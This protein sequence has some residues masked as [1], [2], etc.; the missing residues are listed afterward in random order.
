MGKISD[1]FK[2]I[3]WWHLFSLVIILWIAAI[4]LIPM[5]YPKLEESGQ[6]GDMFGAV[7]AL[8]AGL[9]FAGVIWAIILQKE[10]LELQRQELKETR[11]EIRGQKEQLR[12]QDQTLQ[13][14]NF[15]SSFFQLLDLHS[16]IV[17]S[18]V[19]G[20]K[21]EYS[22]RMCFDFMLKRLKEE[23]D[24]PARA[25]TDFYDLRSPNQ[26]EKTI[27]QISPK[28][29]RELNQI[30]EK[31]FSEHQA[32]VGHY[33]RHLYNAVT[34]VDEHDFFDNF[35]A[36]KAFEKKKFYINLIRAQLSSNELGLLFYNCLSERGSK[37][38]PLVETYSLLKDMD[39]KTIITEN[40]NLHRLL[41]T[42]SSY[43]KSDQK[44]NQ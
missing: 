10:E 18:M 33:F 29:K 9:A 22:G 14:Q 36:D 17:S 19:I 43:G 26:I 8:F 30:Y 15:E 25:F 39:S 23:Y 31:F 24:N 44:E 34:F 4:F 20:Q 16:E 38:K 40:K 32:H 6:F 41:Y 3:R 1:C 13:K 27:N 2:N 11:D 5:Q 37:F 7:N 28:V 21:K 35:C 42:E 12:A